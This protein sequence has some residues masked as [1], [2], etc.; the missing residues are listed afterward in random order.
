MGLL[1]STKH[2]PIVI[3]YVEVPLKNGDVGIYIIKG[4]EQEAKYKDKIKLLETQWHKPTWKETME[5]ARDAT[6]YDQYTGTREVDPLLHRALTIERFLKMW[7]IVDENGNKV[8]CNLDNIAKL[9]VAVAGALLEAFNSYNLP[10]EE[11]LKN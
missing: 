6:V 7:D 3:K 2:F 10:T 8:E 1:I 11:Q 5:V 4:E 9:D